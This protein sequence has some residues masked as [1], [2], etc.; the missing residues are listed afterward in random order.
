MP[1]TTELDARLKIV[2]SKIN[3]AVELPTVAI[4]INDTKIT[5][6]TGFKV[7]GIRAG[8]HGG[9][10]CEFISSAPDPTTENDVERYVYK[11]II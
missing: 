1:N 3:G 8:I 6:K 7:F 11:S 10:Y 5:N 9:K 2:E 4:D